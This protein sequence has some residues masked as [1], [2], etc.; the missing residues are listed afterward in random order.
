VAGLSTHVLDICGGRPAAGVAVDLFR[1]GAD[2]GRTL[3]RR[4][5]TQA[6]GRASLLA[7]DELI[8]AGYE[9]LF[10][11]GAY[12]RAAG[13]PLGDPPFLDQVPIRFAVAEPDRPYHVPLLVSPWGYTTYRGS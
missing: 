10:H 4:V 6:D 7:P 13:T 5:V 9:L 2:G 8:R 12:F 11:V 3:V 1:L